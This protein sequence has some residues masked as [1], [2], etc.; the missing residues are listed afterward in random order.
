[1][2]WEQHLDLILTNWINLS[3]KH[4]EQENIVGELT[5]IQESLKYPCIVMV[6]GEFKTGKSTFINALLGEEV[7]TSDVIPAT[8]VVTKLTYGKKREVI[9]HFIDGQKENYNEEQLKQL[10]VEIKEGEELRKNLSF[11]ELKLPNPLLQTI[12]IVD[13]PGLNSNYSHHTQ[14][15]EMFIKRADFVIWLF[16]YL[17]I[18]TASEVEML[19]K[20]QQYKIPITAFVNR[21]DLH[22]EEQEPL[23]EVLEFN[24]RRLQGIVDSL[25]GISAKEALEAKMSG[26]TLKYEWSNWKMVDSLLKSIQSQTSFYKKERIFTRLR[27]VLQQLDELFIKRKA[28]YLSSQLLQLISSFV[29]EDYPLALQLKKQNEKQIADIQQ[30]YLKWRDLFQ[31]EFL[32]INEVN[33]LIDSYKKLSEELNTTWRL[34]KGKVMNLLVQFWQA[35]CLPMYQLYI[36]NRNDFIHKVK[37]AKTEQETLENL[38][39]DLEKSTKF[40]NKKKLER[41]AVK[42]IEF[43]LLI[44]NLS[45]E[46]A[47]LNLQRKDVLLHLEIFQN[48]LIN[49]ITSK[50]IF[51]KK[52]VSSLIQEWNNEMKKLHETYK[53]FQSEEC[54]KIHEDIQWI[55]SFATEFHSFFADEQGEWTNIPSYPYC[56]YL[57]ENIKTLYDNEMFD[58]FA[59]NYNEFSTWKHLN[60]TYL[61]HQNIKGEIS[62]EIMKDNFYREIP[63]TIDYPT[64]KMI[65]RITL[66][67]QFTI[68]SLI[69]LAYIALSTEPVRKL[70]L[71]TVSLKIFQ[72][73]NELSAST[74][75][76]NKE[77][78]DNEKDFEVR[79]DEAI[80]ND[81]MNGLYEQ[82]TMYLNDPTPYFE[83]QNWFSK[84]GWNNFKPYYQNQQGNN[85]EKM[86]VIDFEYLSDHEIQVTTREI[87]ESLDKTTEY[88][89]VYVLSFFKSDTAPLISQFSYETINITDKEITINEEDLK[90]FLQEF[91]NNYMDALNSN[92]FSLIELYLDEK[93]GAYKELKQ[94]IHSLSGKHFQFQFEQFDILNLQKTDINEYSADTLEKFTFINDTSEKTKYERKKRYI[95]K[96]F[97][98]NDYRIQSI[99]ILDTK[100]EKIIEKT[101][102]YVS[103]EQ[104][105]S[106][107]INFYAD[108]ARAFNGNGF[109]FV[110]KYYAP[111]GN[112]YEEAKQFL[113]FVLEKQMR[114]ENNVFQ[115]TSITPQDDQHYLVDVYLEDSYYYR[116]GTAER[117]K[118]ETQYRV[119]ITPQAEILID[120]ITS[121][122]I[123]EETPL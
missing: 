6:A 53:E 14:A 34:D 123:I 76:E 95:I 122:N 105:E 121:L 12:T 70:L 42:Q 96:V 35:K 52:K 116:D 78:L 118:V 114:M 40:F 50:I 41:F 15:T 98:E 90:H 19:K 81:Y 82:L 94:Y 101:I 37:E 102:D 107:M 4:K 83:W 18:A 25:I 84:S 79:W 77:E 10:T 69:A 51:L 9:A 2:N 80:I 30:Q 56:R 24:K 58:H 47:K 97:G 8:A 106:F 87:F 23:E 26:D 57:F 112:E 29:K 48:H 115:V 66:I 75:S 71:D 73:E 21:I 93:G 13:T 7:L 109:S 36:N 108:F 100:K 86:E 32:N 65:N 59:S 74:W 63:E 39:K 43:N 60:L 91:R 3:R 33:Q 22:D 104:L 68:A 119:T 1:M 5:D 28:M 16:D 46:C 111:N 44:K 103:Y 54:K 110:A 113:E 55:K 89:G 92:D 49:D 11:I 85:Y 67:R 20:L 120:D 17:H 38:L 72:P 31:K 62:L 45:V 64:I 117:K 88:K 99:R 27:D 61:D